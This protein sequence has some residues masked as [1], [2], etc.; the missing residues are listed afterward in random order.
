LSFPDNADQSISPSKSEKRRRILILTA[1]HGNE[2]CGVIAVNELLKE[3]FFDQLAGNV[4]VTII[5]ANPR[6]FEQKKRFLDENL[7][8]AMTN[9]NVDNRKREDGQERTDLNYE[10]RRAAEI[11]AAIKNCDI[12]LDLHSTSAET[13][14]FAIPATD[15]NSETF[16]QQMNIPT[17]FI[18]NRLFDVIQGGG[19]TAQYASQ[20]GKIAIGVECGQHDNP[21]SVQTAKNIIRSLLKDYYIP[22]PTTESEIAP[23]SAA[24]SL[25]CTK[26]EIVR[27]GFKY[28]RE[29]KAFERVSFDEILGIDEEQGELRCPYTEGAYLIMPTS[30]PFLGVRNSNTKHQILTDYYLSAF[31]DDDR[32]RKKHG[33]GD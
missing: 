7:N 19:T 9:E 28:T 23:T 29:V 10:R 31:Y 26:S 17:D 24:V 2:P 14:S 3:G 12:M 33:F 20:L 25:I 1:V 22:H 16:V 13:P 5:L 21:K 30:L 4:Q 32:N 8:R 15:P 27:K 11:G 6:A 18:T